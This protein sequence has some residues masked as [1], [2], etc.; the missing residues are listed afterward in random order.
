M[1]MASCWLTPNTKKS[2]SRAAAPASGAAP[3][4]DA[5]MMRASSP[6]ELIDIG[7]KFQQK[8]RRGWG[9]YGMHLICDL[10]QLYIFFELQFVN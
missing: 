3:V 5:F 7:A 9:S 4:R 1:V 6:T 10:G 8:A 2:E